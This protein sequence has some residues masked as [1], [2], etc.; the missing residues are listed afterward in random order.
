MVGWNLT[1]VWEAETATIGGSNGLRNAIDVGC[2]P[3]ASDPAA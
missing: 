1:S 2:Q 3:T